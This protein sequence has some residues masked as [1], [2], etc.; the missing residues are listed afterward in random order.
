MD[1]LE[2][3]YFRRL[4]KNLGFVCIAIDLELKIR[5]WNDQAT[6][7][8]DREQ[9]EMLDRS[10]L[11]ILAEADRDS[12]K[13]RFEDTIASKTSLEMEVKYLLPDGSRKTMVLITSPI[14]GDDGQC[15]GVSASMRDISRRKRL[16]KELARSR[17][18]AALGRMAGGVAHHFNNILGGM[19]TSID[20]VLTSDSPRELRKTLRLLAQ[21]IG[22]ATRITNQL[23]AFAES[24]NE[25]VEWIE[26]NSIID[27]FVER[28]RPQA[29]RE[30]IHLE[31]A[32]DRIESDPFE[33]ERLMSVLESLAQ[34]AFDAMTE[35]GTLNVAMTGQ[36]DSAIITIQDTGCGIPEDMQDRLFEPFFT[37]K[38]ELAG[39]AGE[40]IG[41][42][43][44][45]VHGLVS[46]MDGNISLTSRVGVGTQAT[47]QLPLR[48][49]AEKVERVGRLGC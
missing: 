47:V 43:L 4:C 19:L 35:G 28:I 3:G 38:G 18:M 11:L 37:T 23:T 17:R 48:R 5:S 21:S 32:I 42:G 7:E 45:A 44:A 24:E 33:S 39:G 41:L 49:P 25:L 31:T 16:S 10:F 2:D 1:E 40:N 27:R 34:N 9:A 15:I 13:R 46:E 12:A 14:I 6:R 30:G 29:Q 8:F 20:C 36:G 26:L 22:R